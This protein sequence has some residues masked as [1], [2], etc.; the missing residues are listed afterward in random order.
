[1]RMQNITV[2]LED[3]LAVSYETK[4]VLIIWSTN[5]L[6]FNQMGEKND[7]LTHMLIFNQKKQKFLYTQMLAHGIYTSFIHKY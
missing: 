2:N 3:S 7:V 5:V 6:L 4:Y 1:M